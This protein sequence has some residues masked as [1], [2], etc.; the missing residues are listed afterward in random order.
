LPELPGPLLR[1]YRFR[2]HLGVLGGKS[3]NSASQ[4]APIITKLAPVPNSKTRDTTPTIRAKVT[5][6]ETN[7]AKSNIK[8]FVDDKARS[9]SYDRIKDTLRFTPKL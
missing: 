8:L 7:L 9:F 6:K 2:Q 3:G 1:N 4:H 5:D